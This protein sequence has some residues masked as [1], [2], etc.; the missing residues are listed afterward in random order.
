MI[1]GY[2]LFMIMIIISMLRKLRTN[3]CDM[4]RV[5]VDFKMD[6]CRTYVAIRVY[7][8]HPS[9]QTCSPVKRVFSLSLKI[10]L[11]ILDTLSGHRTPCRM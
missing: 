1:I 2:G 10:A 11:P 9:I 8:F 7:L 4:E 3:G 5:A 6:A